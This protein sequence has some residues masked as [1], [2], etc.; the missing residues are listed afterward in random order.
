[1][2]WQLRAQPERSSHGEGG[3]RWEGEGCGS[4]GARGLQLTGGSNAKAIPCCMLR[5]GPSSYT[6]S[7]VLFAQA[8]PPALTVVVYGDED[9]LHVRQRSRCVP[10]ARRCYGTHKAVVV[11]GLLV[12]KWCECLK[13]A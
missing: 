12:L 3:G 5:G 11:G 9:F 1:M 8:Q 6:V 13:S 2:G 10:H 4:G 7:R